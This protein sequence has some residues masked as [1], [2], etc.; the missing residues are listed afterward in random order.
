MLSLNHKGTKRKK[1]NLGVLCAFA[2]KILIAF[3]IASFLPRSAHAQELPEAAF[4]EGVIGH[5]QEHNLSCES[6]SAIDLAA[7]WGVA[8]TRPYMRSRFALGYCLWRQGERTEALT[9][10]RDLIS[11]NPNDNQGARYVL[12]AA[13]LEL[14]EDRE[15]QQVMARYS[16]DPLCHWAYNRALIEFRRHGDQRRTQRLLKQAFKKSALA[17]V[18]LLGRKRTRSYEL[19]FVGPGEESEATEYQHLY[20]DAWTMTEGAL[21]WLEQQFEA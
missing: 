20:G 9:H 18:F 3:V 4:I 2:V 13:L 10:F 19:D 8:L 14:G 17:P 16:R 7:F 5:P 15:A 11:L 1:R 6:R 21:A 12:V